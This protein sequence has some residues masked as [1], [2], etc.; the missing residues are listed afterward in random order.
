M[1]QSIT[2]YP[3]GNAECVLLELSNGK[4]MLMDYA[5][6]HNKDDRY[7]NLP[8][9][10]ADIDTFDVVMFSHP[11]DDHVKGA[12][13]YFFFKH[14]LR[15]Q[16]GKR[17]KIKNLWISA[18]FLLD[19]NPCEDARVIR[20]EAR[21]RLKECNGE[22]VKIFAAPDTLSSWLKDN[23]LSEEEISQS[24]VHAGALL[25]NS[26]HNLGNEI[27]IFVHAPFSEDADDADSRNDPSIVLQIS[28][29]NSK[30]QTDIL[31]TG[32]TP[33]DVLDKIIERSEENGNDDHL[34]WDLY[35]IPHHCSYTGLSSERGDK[36]T[37]PTE[38]IKRLLGEYGQENSFLVASC[39]AFL[40]VDEDDNQPP[41]IEAKEAYIKHSKNSDETDKKLFVTSE[42][43]GKINPK[44]LHFKIDETGI[45]EDMRIK[46][47]FI[48]SPASRAG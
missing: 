7:A 8:R 33:Y 31:I 26:D 37:E 20:Q 5:D 35:D 46:P 19:V 3:E 14:A 12:A 10:F 11:H 2:F 1:G 6:M 40:D 4:R 30:Q 16:N 41:H 47:S 44:P 48:S 21:Y 22:G 43:R 24:I 13:D 34:K 15:Y 36:I 39:R 45:R 23:G 42:Y 18:A 9:L 32:D 28:L 27:S 17:A 25:K 38:N 29:T